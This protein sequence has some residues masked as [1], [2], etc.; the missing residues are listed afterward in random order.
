MGHQRLVRRPRVGTLGRADPDRERAI[1][2]ASNRSLTCSYGG[3][4]RFPRAPSRC[5]VDCWRGM[6]TRGQQRELP[7]HW[8]EHRVGWGI[9]LGGH[10]ESS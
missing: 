5:P 9:W 8:Q 7:L 1:S 4:R 10:G 2:S 3:L 6:L